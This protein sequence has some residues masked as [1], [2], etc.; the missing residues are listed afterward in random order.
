MVDEKLGW[1]ISESLQ[2][3]HKGSWV[4]G[5]EGELII[6]LP[7]YIQ[8]GLHWPGRQ[9]IPSQRQMRI[10]FSRFKYGTSWMECYTP[11]DEEH[12]LSGLDEQVSDSAG[13]A[14]LKLSS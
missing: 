14:I 4:L 13:F 9:A 2:K 7:A 5:P 8:R 10:D 6:W 1:R 11:P 12:T 3:N